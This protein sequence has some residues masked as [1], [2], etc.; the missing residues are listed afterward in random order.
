MSDL[1]ARIEALE[2]AQAARILRAVAKYRV[3]R[4]LAQELAPDTALVADLAAA[5]GTSAEAN[6]DAG[7]VAEASL[8][9]LA[10]D[11]AMVPVLDSM[12]DNPPAE[13]FAVDPVTLGVG[14]GALVVLQS[15]IKIERDKNGKWTFKFEKKPM[16]DTLLAKVISK[17]GGWL[18]GT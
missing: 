18:R 11:P 10:A 13:D 16:S 7:D 3:S 2:P 14:V 4:G 8:I 5:A 17:L 6:A 12:I 9:L 15:Y 1:A